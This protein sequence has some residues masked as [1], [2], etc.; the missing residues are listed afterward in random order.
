[1]SQVPHPLQLS[2]GPMSLKNPTLRSRSLAVFGS[3]F[4]LVGAYFLAT[5]GVAA[6]AK[7]RS[8][9]CTHGAGG[10]ELA[11]QRFCCDFTDGGYTCGCTFYVVGC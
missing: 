3:A 4:L 11:Y 2:E 9:V 6:A 5:P 1:M 7:T 8:C 10:C